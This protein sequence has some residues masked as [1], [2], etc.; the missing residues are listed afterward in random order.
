MKSIARQQELFPDPV[1]S[2]AKNTSVFLDNMSLPVHRWFRYSA[3]FSAAWVSE[4]IQSHAHA[5]GVRV[6]DPFVGSGTTCVAAQSVGAESRGIESHPFVVRIARA[7]LNWNANPDLLLTRARQVMTD[8]RPPV[9]TDD[10]APLLK[11]CFPEGTL[12]KL[13]SLREGI[14]RTSEDG[15]IDELLWLALVSILRQ[16]SPIG[17]AQWQ[18]VLPN[19]RKSR[20]QEPY[21]AFQ[22]QIAMMAMDMQFLQD[23]GVLADAVVLADDARHCQSMP[24]GWANL[25]I[26]S[27]PYPNNFDYAD[28]TR[29]EMTFLGD[30]DG[31]GDLQDKVRNYLVHSCSQHMGG[32]KPED[33][34]NSPLLSPIAAELEPVFRK[35]A[36]LRS[37]RAGH[38]A[39]HSMVVAYFYD[40]AQVWQSLRRVMAEGSEVCFVVG[41]SAPY[42]V[43]VPVERWLGELALAAGFKSYNFDKLRDRNIKWK[44]RKHRVPL[45]E[46][47][48]W[49][50]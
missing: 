41:D 22:A 15:P 26:T 27:P 35:L 14:K 2:T 19:K 18:Y 49:V 25:A 43:H 39:Y 38:K 30:L 11:K 24:T 45:H 33:A 16:C 20:V 28:A 3:G 40:L 34:L 48:L 44:N 5:H 23:T 12:R 37:Q 42:G 7:K 8:V 17:T 21:K 50:D 32:Y 4:V 6:F 47:R 46:G 13:I 29:L 10:I 36:E 31:W 9:P 1:A